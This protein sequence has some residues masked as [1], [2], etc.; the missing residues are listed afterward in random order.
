MT[1]EKNEREI[2]SS[3]LKSEGKNQSDR[4]PA[5]RGNIATNDLQ[6]DSQIQDGRCLS[7]MASYN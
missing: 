6:E 1:L 7:D 2:W 3:E 5:Q 4:E